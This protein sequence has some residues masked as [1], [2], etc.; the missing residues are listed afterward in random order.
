[1]ALTSVIRVFDQPLLTAILLTSSAA[2]QTN[3]QSE[4]ADKSMRP[5]EIGR[6]GDGSQKVVLSVGVRS[7]KFIDA[8]W[9][10]KHRQAQRK[11][12]FKG[13][14]PQAA[15]FIQANMGIYSAQRGGGNKGLYV[16]AR[17]FFLLLLNCSA[18]PC[19]G[20][21]W[22]NKQTYISPSVDTKQL[23]HRRYTKHERK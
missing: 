16:V 18:W 7:I 5:S 4:T 14:A 2:V 10:N 8:I 3:K 23:A 6:A 21:A 22:K 13:G 19:L 17:N 15:S 20:P 12:I 11:D 9:P 1:M